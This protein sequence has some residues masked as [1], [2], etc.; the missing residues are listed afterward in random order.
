MKKKKFKITNEELKEL[1]KEIRSFGLEACIFS[2]YHF[3][4][5]KEEGEFALD[6]FPTSRTFCKKYDT[7]TTKGQPFN[8]VIELIEKELV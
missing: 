8:D 1:C 5:S 4:V 6:I 7:Y 3:R 2:P